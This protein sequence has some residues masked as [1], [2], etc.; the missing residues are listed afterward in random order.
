MSA[1]DGNGAFIVS[2]KRNNTKIRADRAMA[3]AEDTSLLYKRRIEDL[4][5]AI[6]RMERERENM[7]DLSPANSMSLV[8]AS[9]FK[10]DE[11]VEKDIELG[12]K[13]RNEKIKLE[14][15]Q[16]QYDFLF[17]GEGLVE[18]AKEVANG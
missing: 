18:P 15:A 4:E 12:V 7:L 6:R 5:V 13:I 16:K 3:I 11:F 14:I 9:D 2:L 17:V 8:L 1:I 10:A